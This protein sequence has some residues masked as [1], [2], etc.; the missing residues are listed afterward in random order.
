MAPAARSGEWMTLGCDRMCKELRVT[1]RNIFSNIRELERCGLVLP[2]RL[3]TSII[4]RLEFEALKADLAG[5][6]VPNDYWQARCIQQKS[7]FY[8][9]KPGVSRPSLPIF[10]PFLPQ[11]E[12]KK[13]EKDVG[14]TWDGPEKD[15][16]SAFELETGEERTC[17]T[18]IP[19]PHDHDSEY[20]HDMKIEMD[21]K[22]LEKYTFLKSIHE[23][24][25]GST[26]GE[27]SDQAAAR[28]SSQYEM[29]QF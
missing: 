16:Q 18:S 14:W 5:M 4:T 26:C 17:S 12:L 9:L 21:P 13:A 25:P 20:E 22:Q 8:R 24:F 19:R 15:V 11:S 23:K 10:N 6:D 28:L 3:E 7:T 29:P 27:M 1:S 2:G